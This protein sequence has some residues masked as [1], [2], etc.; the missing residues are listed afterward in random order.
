M[1]NEKFKVGD[2][3][4][5]I[6]A[7]SIEPYELNK[8]GTIVS[9]EAYDNEW[10]NYVVDMGRPRRLREPEETCWWL[11]DNM[12]ELAPRKNQQLLFNFMNEF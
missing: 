7:S 6:K 12:I 2:T 10:T 4:R 1:G 11:Q 5:I 9:I 3:V 8:V